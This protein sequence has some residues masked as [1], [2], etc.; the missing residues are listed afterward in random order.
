MKDVGSLL[1]PV[2]RMAESVSPQSRARA[3][4][5]LAWLALAREVLCPSSM[6][7]E[8]LRK[9]CNSYGFSF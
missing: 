6:I 3:S 2:P 1:A 4:I 8:T 5:Y 9:S 7:R